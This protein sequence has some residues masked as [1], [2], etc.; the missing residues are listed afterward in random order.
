MESLSTD[1]AKEL[2]LSKLNCT[3]DTMGLWLYG[4]AIGMD[5]K[6]IAKIMMSPTAFSLANTMRGNVFNGDT[7]VSIN[8]LGSY[9]N[10]GP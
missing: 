8:R 5:F 6:D 3:T 9:V 2:C 1:N 10:D 7:A 4:L